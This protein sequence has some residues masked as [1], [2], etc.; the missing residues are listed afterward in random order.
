MYSIPFHSIPSHLIITFKISFKKKLPNPEHYGASKPDYISW[1]IKFRELYLMKLVK[2]ICKT[3]ALCAFYTGKYTMGSMIR[4]AGE[5]HRCHHK[6][7]HVQLLMSSGGSSAGGHSTVQDKI[8]I[9]IDFQV[10]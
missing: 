2:S 4:G 5:P 8:S 3:Q 6:E 10:M 9:L 7:L 1:S